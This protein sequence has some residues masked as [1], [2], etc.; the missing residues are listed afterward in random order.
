MN[1]G[2]LKLHQLLTFTITLITFESRPSTT[3]KYTVAR[4]TG[5][6]F[7][8]IQPPLSTR[9]SFY[10]TSL[11]SPFTSLIVLQPI[12]SFPTNQCAPTSTAHRL[13]NEFRSEFGIF[14][15]PPPVSSPITHCHVPQATNCT[16]HHTGFLL[17]IKV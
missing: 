8:T 14:S 1:V 5:Y 3:Q 15:V 12:S 9:S 4:E 11:P 17:K 2:R 16:Y 7:F 13:R 10:L 6:E